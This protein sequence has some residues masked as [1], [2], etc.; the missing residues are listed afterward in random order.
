M[1]RMY[2]ILDFV[3]TR[4]IPHPNPLPPIGR[5]ERCGGRYSYVMWVGH[6]RWGARPTDVGS[7]PWV[8]HEAVIRTSPASIAS[9]ALLPF[10]ERRGGEFFRIIAASIWGLSGRKLVG[11][12][13]NSSSASDVARPSALRTAIWGSAARHCSIASRAGAVAS[14]ARRDG[15]TFAG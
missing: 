9:L 14:S 11:A 12:S 13:F 15:K 10:A 3:W 1:D 2:R 4:L 5:G 7:S 6:P 8:N